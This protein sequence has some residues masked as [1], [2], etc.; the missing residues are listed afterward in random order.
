MIKRDVFIL[1]DGTGI[2]A[3]TL[4]NSLISQ[5]ESIHFEKTTI[6]YI[7][8]ID[9][10]QEVVQKINQ[11]SQARGLQP[12]VFMT[13]VQPH[14]RNE[15]LKANASFYDLFNAFIEP[16]EKELHA[17]SSYSVGRS[18]G[19]INPETYNQRID[20]V[21]FALNHDDGIKVNHY[22]NADII[23][24]GVSRCGK[25]PTCL[26]MALQFGILAAN[27][28]IT[29]EDLNQFNLPATLKPYKN[30]LFGLTIDPNRLR[31]IRHERRPNSRYSSLEQCRLEVSEVEAMYQHEKISYLNSTSYSIEEIATRIMAQ[32]NIKQ[33]IS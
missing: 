6:P 4:S 7:G 32:A 29:D 27:Y 16:L 3:N 23:L 8:S 10:A 21:N 1:S 28:P 31:Q 20:A 30:K 22:Q 26:F 12:I 11:K 19:V 18:H 25:T 24:V 9:K 5:F 2:T 15:I 33:R 13:L 14:I 17:K